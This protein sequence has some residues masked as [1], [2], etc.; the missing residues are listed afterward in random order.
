MS[1][2][3]HIKTWGCQMNEYD[4]Q[5]MADLLDATNGYQLTEEAADADVI[6]LNTCSI[7]EKAQEKVFHQLGRWKLLKD[8]KPDLIIGVG[9]CVASQEGDSIRQRAPF[10]DVIFGPQTL[11][12]LPEMIKQVQGNK[13]SSVVDISFP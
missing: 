12:R 9:G 7:R 5:K 13:G 8:D 6:L 2:K 4:S 10:V 3:L 11:H 1:K